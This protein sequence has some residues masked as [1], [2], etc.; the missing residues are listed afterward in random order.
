MAANLFP[1][2]SGVLPNTAMRPSLCCPDFI[3]SVVAASPREIKRARVW[4]PIAVAKSPS[5]HENAEI[6]IHVMLSWMEHFCGSYRY[7]TISLR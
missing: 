1:I 4:N 5:H 3:T 2:Q 6:G 7:E